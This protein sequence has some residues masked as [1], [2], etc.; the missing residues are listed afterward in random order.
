MQ[1]S[2]VVLAGGRGSRMGGLDKG[3]VE[4]MGKPMVNH[5]IARIQPQVSELFINANRELERYNDLGLSVIQDEIPD[6]AGPLAGLHKAMKVANTPYVLAVPCDTP[7]LPTNLVERMMNT[8]IAQDAEIVV[9]KT[10]TQSHPVFCLCRKSLLPSLE[11][12]LQAGGRKVEEW[13]KQHELAVVFFDENPKA[14][15]NVNTQDELAALE[16]V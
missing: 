10:G 1:I 5:V 12:F 6:F 7:L 3:W 9:A 8:M 4:F 2:G 13:Q 16:K 15:A 14:F 11:A